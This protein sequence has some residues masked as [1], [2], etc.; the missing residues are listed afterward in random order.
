MIQGDTASPSRWTAIVVSAKPR[1]RR[2]GGSTF[3]MAA[4]KGPMLKKSRKRVTNIDGQKTFG[5]GES[6]AGIVNAIEPTRLHPETEN[7][8]PRARSDSRSPS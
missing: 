6:T 1:A 3:A 4:F 5:V 8:A 7:C 2:S